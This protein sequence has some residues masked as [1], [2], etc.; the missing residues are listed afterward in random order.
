L[1]VQ[2]TRA[3]DRKSKSKGGGDNNGKS[4]RFGSSTM[5]VTVH[6]WRVDGTWYRRQ[7]HVRIFGDRHRSSPFGVVLEALVL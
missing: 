4:K 2:D 7:V 6:Q 1:G 3:G 5:E